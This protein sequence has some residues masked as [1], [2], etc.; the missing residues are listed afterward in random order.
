MEFEVFKEKYQHKS[1]VEYPNRVIDKPA[2]SV[3]VPTYQHVAYIQ[4]CLD[5]IIKQKTTF[6]FEI[7]VG[8]DNSTDGTR[9][10]CIKYANRY[11][12]K[13]RLL[14]HNKENKVS[15]LGKTTGGFNNLYN[16][17]SAKGKYIARCEGDDYWTDI[18]KLQK[19]FDFM[20][21]NPNYFVCGHDAFIAGESGI[22][23][24]S[25]LPDSQKRDLS[26]D[27]NQYGG[28]I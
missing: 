3:C 19:Q 9:E 11:P 7:I 15:V 22:V 14:L 10:I 28:F 2:V 8:E 18:Y 13:I 6:P 1:V 24:M 21:A 27:Q 4:E 23:K 20:E 25:K 5:S 26:S 16:F 12:T 17:Y